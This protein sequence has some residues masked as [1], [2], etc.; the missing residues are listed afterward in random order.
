MTGK[1]AV[2]PTHVRESRVIQA[3]PDQVWAQIRPLT[4][5]F[6]SSVKECKVTEGTVAEVGSHRRVH[7]TDGTVQ[8]LKVLEINDL[9]FQITYEL[10]WSEPAVT[11]TSAVHTIKLHHVTYDNSSVVEWTSDYSNDATQEVV[12]DS[13]FK[14]LE[15]FEDLVK[16]LA[17]GAKRLASPPKA[18]AT[19]K[20]AK[21]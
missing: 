18:S 13:K 11:V 1:T 14:K 10:I 2:A 6:S 3:S 5:P 9:L 15:A 19:P 7:Y 8:T 17:N 20:K 4:F 16:H 21:K 12:Q